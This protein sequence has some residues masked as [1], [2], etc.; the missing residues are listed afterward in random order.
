MCVGEDLGALAD[1]LAARL[2]TPS[3]DLLSPEL[4]VVPTAAIGSWLESRLSR[5]L[6][7]A[8]REDGICANVS[9][10]FA[11]ALV[12]RLVGSPRGEPDPWSV[13]RMTLLALDELRRAR[14]EGVA[15]DGHGDEGGGGLHADARALASLFDQLFRWRPDVVD[16]WLD[17]SA[18]DPRAPVL[19]RLVERI[20]AP[21]PHR[22]V[23][24]A[25]ARLA[26]GDDLGVDLPG[27]LHVFCGDSLEGGATM[28]AALDALGRVREVCAHV[29]VVSTE[30]FDAVRAATPSWAGG[31]PP[32][33]H[34]ADDDAHALVRSWGTTRSDTAQ[35]LAQLPARDTTRLV[36]IGAVAS[37]G[38]TLLSELQRSLRGAAQDAA[39]ADASISVHGCVGPQRQVEVARD[40]ILHALAD[41]PTLSPEDVLVACADPARFAPFVEAV[42]GDRQ[43]APELPYVLRD[44]SVS[45]AVPLIAAMDAALRLVGGRVSR[46]AVL[47]L[48]RVDA[49]QRRFGLGLEDVD[50][51]AEWTAAGDVRWG[52]DGRHRA[53]AG[54]PITFDVG[55]W[56]RALD[57]V[58]AGMAV[59]DRASTDALGL[60]AIDAGHEHE[61]V[62][63]A[64]EVLD[65]LVALRAAAV[66]PRGVA[67]WCDF[68]RA[69]LDTCFSPTR[70][71][72]DAVEQLNRLLDAI[73]VDDPA[74]DVLLTYPEFVALFSDR[75]SRERDVVPAGS[76]GVTVTSLWALRNVPF[77][78]IVLLGLDERAVERAS[79]VDV[80][81][82]AAR[83]G[84]RDTRSDVRAA[85]LG[86]LLAAASRLV[87]VHESRDVVSNE[88]SPP[89]TVLAELR[90]ALGTA[91][92]DG[93]G[94]VVDHPRHAHS[95]DDLA[96]ADG[97]RP[98]TFDAGALR[99]AT[100][101]RGTPRDVAAPRADLAGAVP[102][103]T[104]RVRRTE[105]VDFLLRPQRT[106]LLLAHG[107]RLP[108]QPRPA[109]DELATSLD[110]L[111]QW[112]ATTDLVT[113]ALDEFDDTDAWDDYVEAW[114]ARPD[115]VVATLPGR[116]R[117]LELGGPTGI[118]AKAADVL[119]QVRGTIGDRPMRREHVEV[120]VAG[121]T[122]IVGDVDVVGPS[123]IVH[124]TASTN[125]RR[126][127]VEATIDLLLLTVAQ[128]ETEWHS[129]R[130]LRKG[131]RA[132]CPKKSIFAETPDG[133]RARAQLA[134]DRLV[135]LYRLGLAA[136]IPLFQRVVD[137]MRNEC[138]HG[139][140]APPDALIEAG[141]SAWKPFFVPGDGD[142]EAVRYCFDASY[143]ELAALPVQPGDPEVPFD[144]GG[145][146]MVTYSFALLDALVEL[147]GEPDGAA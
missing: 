60:R 43:G 59:S 25:L 47:D 93:D 44:R 130:I 30:R 56:R 74:G 75:A 14:A 42:L 62:G 132:I 4:V 15:P 126:L 54:L 1:D 128:P 129:V 122:T 124:W 117:A 61:R 139:V 70:E 120:P 141:F 9:M 35:L 26:T 6:G 113:A 145:S 137:K 64:C 41:D 111:E 123:R 136:P 29:V 134:L 89:A 125:D 49:V 46:G 36:S 73:E 17:G 147:D 138:K 45:R 38:S 57:R 85:L 79:A 55:T 48:L 115:G 99:R 144:T 121:G 39:A 80:A 127:L 12:R 142:D 19:A 16:A 95:D 143:E 13:D 109:P 97:R 140:A 63:A 76:G 72:G 50:R 53:S 107:I 86:A 22:V 101:L 94:L 106:Y 21:P 28:V 78:V 91:C 87:V 68:S 98:F 146:R 58:V 108:P 84:D 116:F 18:R 37:S 90:E 135:E 11:D 33:R 27:R 51:L 2:A 8:G 10:I 133:R 34:A 82:G 40:A 100:E 7:A 103:A 112:R 81:L 105:L 5:V 110:G 69:V 118:R 31:P 3:G 114:A 52:L 20:D 32:P 88:S 96:H 131:R 65:A 83:V 104:D 23:H 24:E 77:R 102:A 92:R 71:E 67:G 119:A 66:E